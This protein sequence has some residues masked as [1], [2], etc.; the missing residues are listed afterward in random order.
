MPNVHR[1]Q[2]W[3]LVLFVC[4]LFRFSCRFH[5][6]ADSGLNVRWPLNSSFDQGGGLPR[7]GDALFGPF[8]S[9]R[10]HAS[11]SGV[12]RCRPWGCSPLCCC[13]I[14][15][16]SLIKKPQNRRRH[17]RLDTRRDSYKIPVR[18]FQDNQIQNKCSLWI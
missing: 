13:W 14:V 18:V 15:A 4:H 3:L 10:S 17:E 8:S 2:E 6:W 9:P 7:T 12:V 1:F 5:G 11:N 16:D